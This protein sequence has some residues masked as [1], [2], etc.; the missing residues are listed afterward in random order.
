M[1]VPILPIHVVWKLLNGDVWTL[2]FDVSFCPTTSRDSRGFVIR[3]EVARL[4][5][6]GETPLSSIS[7]N[8]IEKQLLWFGL[9]VV[10]Q[11]IYFQASNSR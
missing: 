9:R 5:P 1:V 7:A 10:I 6:I 8:E 3:D 11:T 4:R 2:F